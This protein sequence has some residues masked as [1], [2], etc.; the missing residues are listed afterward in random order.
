ME[1]QIMWGG[2]IF[3]GGWLWFY[4]M[5][6]QLIFNFTTVLPMIKRFKK[7]G[8]ELMSVNASR[9]VVISILVWTAIAGGI[10]A[11]VII[12]AKTYMW[13]AFLVGGLV[14]IL[15]YIGRYGPYTKANFNDFCSA[16]YRFVP[17]DELRTDMYN[18][19]I[20]QMKTR[21]DDMGID[22]TIVIP[23]FKRDK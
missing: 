16:Y 10:A 4:L 9:F 6:R 8:P 3:L 15:S 14:G 13:I 21:L 1:K 11:L 2:L 19:K 20:G 22:K 23:E 5:L 18:N 17:D 12:F 7:A